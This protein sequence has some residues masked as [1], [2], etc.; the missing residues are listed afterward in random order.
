VNTE[1]MLTFMKLQN[2]RNYKELEFNLTDG[3]LILSG[4]NGTGKSN[5]LESIFYLGT[6]YSNRQA[7]DDV[8]IMWG[9]PFFTIN[10]IVIQRG[11][12][13]TLDIIYNSKQ[14]RKITKINGKKTL[15]GNCAN[16]LPVVIFS[17]QDLQII[18]GGP[19]GRRIF[20]DL[21]VSQLKPQHNVDLHQ[22]RVALAQRNKLLRSQVFSDAELY[23]WDRQLA[24]VG[25]RIWKRRVDVFKQIISIISGF[26]PDLSDGESLMG[27]YVSQVVTTDANGVSDYQNSFLA[28]LKG[29]REYDQRLKMTTLGP[30]RDDFQ[31]YLN[32]RE[33][34]FYASQGEQRLIT[35][36][37]KIA[38]Y[39]LI[40]SEQ[41]LEPLLLLDDVF[42][43]LDERRRCLVIRELQEGSQVIATT[44]NFL[45]K[46]YS[47]KDKLTDDIYLYQLKNY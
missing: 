2:F 13:Y 42:S 8:L 39:K 30:H 18:Q 15:S 10:G 16:L 47:R 17:P 3:F 7:R 35:L 22:Y 27:K 37:L 24:T 43:E 33:A 5:L 44:V 1:P 23:P 6:G 34:R 26:F 46:G 21:V 9:A 20:L 25:A 40:A 45:K 14:K 38:H 19:A 11:L 12:E 32:G 29:A 41:G 4:L 31:M 36:A 28:A